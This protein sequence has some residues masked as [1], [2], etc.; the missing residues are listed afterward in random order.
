MSLDVAAKVVAREDLSALFKAKPSAGLILSPSIGEWIPMSGADLIASQQRTESGLRRA[1]VEGQDRVVVALNSGGDGLGTR[2]AIG[3]ASIGAAATSVGPRGRMRLLQS[4]EGLA[5]TV[6]IATP[7][8]AMDFL[9]RLHLE[10]L[11][12]PLDL[13]LRLLVLTGETAGAGVYRHLAKEFDAEVVAVMTDPVAGLPIMVWNSA[14]DDET[15]VSLEDDGTVTLADIVEDGLPNPGRPAEIVLRHRWHSQLRDVQVRSGLAL[16]QARLQLPDHTVGN[17]ILIRGRWVPLNLLARA[18]SKIDGISTWTLV[19]ER[20]GTL[21]QAYVEITFSRES[22]LANG[23]WQGRIEDALKSV[24][25]VHIG[26][27]IKSE[28]AETSQPFRVNDQRGHHLGVDRAGLTASLSPL[29]AGTRQGRQE[30]T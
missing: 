6:L 15:D 27:T 9:A 16:R 4:I 13:A 5:A 17:H 22:L 19:V 20:R 18:L 29:R 8:G 1:G 25:P 14:S 26:L 28:I 23:M 24:T 3:A 21:D 11:V 7:T 30:A 10:F 12:D 2:F